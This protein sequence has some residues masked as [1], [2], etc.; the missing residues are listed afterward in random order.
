MAKD[1]RALSREWFEV[2]WNNRDD[3]G[4]ERLAAPDVIVNGLDESGKP[5]IGT[6]LFRKF[7]AAFLS[8]FPD[9]HIDVEDVMVEGDKTAVRLRFSGTHTGQGIGIPPT[10][11]PFTATAIVIIRWREGKIAESW[12]EFDAAGMTRQ[13]QAPAAKLRP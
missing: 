8:A 7:R 11:N 4:I 2:V 12:N 9:I 13:L 1:I 6:Q 3:S 10:G 5:V